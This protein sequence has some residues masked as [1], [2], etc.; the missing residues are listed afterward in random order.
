MEKNVCDD[1]VIAIVL[2]GGEGR[3]GGLLLQPSN[4]RDRL[5]TNV[6]AGQPH[7]SKASK[8]TGGTADGA[9]L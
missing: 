1:D 2:E 8:N 7:S 9:A 3:E 4:A 6:R 5:L